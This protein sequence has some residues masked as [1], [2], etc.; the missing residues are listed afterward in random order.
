MID[1]YWRNTTTDK[2]VAMRYRVVDNNDTSKFTKHKFDYVK[3]INMFY[4]WTDCY[5]LPPSVWIFKQITRPIYMKPWVSFQLRDHQQDVINFVREQIQQW[6]RSCFIE[7]ATWSGKTYMLLWICNLIWWR[8]IIGVPTKAIWNQIVE[9]ISQY[10]HCWW[11]KEWCDFDVAVVCHKTLNIKYDDI[12]NTFDV[13][14]L[15]ELHNLPKKR[16]QQIVLRKW[17]FVFW[18]TATPIRKEFG[19]EWFKM[20]LWWYFNTWV[21][22]LPVHVFGIHSRINISISEYN[23]QL[24]DLPQESP[25]ILRRIIINNTSRNE[26][27]VRLIKRLRSIWLTKVIFFSDRTQHLEILSSLIGDE[28]IL[29]YGKS[30]IV[31][32]K[33]RVLTLEKYVILGNIKTCWEWFDLPELQCW[34]LWVSTSWVKSIIQMAWRMV[35]PSWN[36]TCAYFIDIFDTLT[37]WQSRP[38][39]LGHYQRRKIYREMGRSIN[40]ISLLPTFLQNEWNN[41]TKVTSQSIL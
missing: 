8:A 11:Y 31:K 14:L 16:I 22:T 5:Y 34:I 7:S 33:E 13:L 40:D 21:K 41:S 36:K 15:D 37:V 20:L 30:D 29:F 26:M 18:C 2:W 38:K 12:A 1:K 6:R 23:E 4:K 35:R 39:P 32:A 3:Y 24:G 19:I 28:S 27:I 17:S 10:Y 9:T 25:E